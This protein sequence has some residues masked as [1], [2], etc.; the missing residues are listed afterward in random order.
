MEHLVADAHPALAVQPAVA[1]DQ[2]H[3][4]ALQPRDLPGV[5]ETADELVAASQDRLHVELAGNRL[6]CPGNA[7]RFG[8]R[9]SRAQQRLGRHARVVRAL[10]PDQLC[11]HN[12]HVMAPP[13][14][15][16]G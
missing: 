12:G 1:A 2:R 16:S 13:G 5:V 10:T 6:R 8:Q 7:A 14:Q 15:P 9:L 11:L 4:P 3:T